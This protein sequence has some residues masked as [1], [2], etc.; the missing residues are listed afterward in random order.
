[1]INLPINKIVLLKG[2]Y[3]ISYSE[4]LAVLTVACCAEVAQDETKRSP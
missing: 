4:S 3:K 2:W 1:M